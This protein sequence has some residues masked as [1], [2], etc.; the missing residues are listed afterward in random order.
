MKHPARAIE[1]FAG[2]K[3]TC[4]EKYGSVAIARELSAF[5]LSVC[6]LEKET[7]LACHT[8]S[9]NDGMIHPGFAAPPGTLK[10]QLNVEG[11]RL[12]TDIC[13]NLSVP[14]TRRGSLLLLEKSSYRL[15]VPLMLHRAGKNQVDGDFR[16]ISKQQ[17]LTMEPHLTSRQHGGLFFPSAGQLS[18]Y[19]LTIALAEHAVQNGVTV[20][21]QAPVTGFETDGKN[22]S[23]VLTSRGSV[24]TRLVINASG[25]WADQTAEKAADQFYTLHFRKGTECIL[26]TAAGAFQTIIAGKPDLYSNR[27]SN[28]KG[29][30]IVPCIEGN[31]LIGPTAA[32]VFSRDDYRTEAHEMKYLLELMNINT[33]FKAS[34]IIT[35]FSGIRACSWNEDFILTQSPA[36]K[37]IIHAAGIQSPGLASAPAIAK[38]TAQLCRSFFGDLKPN[39]AYCRQRKIRTPITLNERIKI[40]E[41]R[42]DYAHIICRCETVSEG[43]VRDALRRN[44]TPTTLDG[45]KRR[46]RCGTG[47]CQGAFCTPKVLRIME[48]EL[49]IPIE[50]IEKSGYGSPVTAGRTKEAADGL[51]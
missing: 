50:N 40:L 47:R 5:R 21:L 19:T 42:P 28:S 35:Y 30:G 48:Q 23:R 13:E 9:R 18:P 12:Y 17:I 7:D 24:R 33:A 6:L 3:V 11:N 45:V 4:T 2:R 25:C 43:E 36:G 39:P 8:S 10:A 46:T 51:N 38:R 16:Y 32:E 20:C 15:L 44:P 22:I 29:G 14:F 31:I 27:N 1:S 34:D 37:N 41:K 49:R 26:D